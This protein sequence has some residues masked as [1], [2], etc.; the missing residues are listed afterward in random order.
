MSTPGTRTRN[1]QAAGRAEPVRHRM[2]GVAARCDRRPHRPDHRRAQERCRDRQRSAWTATFAYLRGFT[3]RRG[4]GL[5][6]AETPWDL[7]EAAAPPLLPG[8]LVAVRQRRDAVQPG[9][10]ADDPLSGCG[11]PDTMGEHDLIDTTLNE[12]VESR[13]PGQRARPVREAGR[14]NG[15]AETLAPR[16][17][18]TSQPS[19]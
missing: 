2:D 9:T 4:H 6:A 12:L 18:P 15:P 19:H 3:W 13:M 5:A 14:R 1:Q 17:G 7:V 8:R 10:D 11:N 16:R